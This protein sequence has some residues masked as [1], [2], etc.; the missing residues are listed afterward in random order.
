LPRF[1][2][3]LVSIYTAGTPVCAARQRRAMRLSTYMLF[4]AFGL[5]CLP[6]RAKAAG[7]I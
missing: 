6:L 7:E 5:D 3:A 2:G 4:S 1:C